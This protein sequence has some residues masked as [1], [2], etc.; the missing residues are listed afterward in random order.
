MITGSGVVVLDNDDHV[1]GIVTTDDLSKQLRGMS[2]ELAV[3]Y[4][5]LSRKNH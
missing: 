1:G 4:S 3:K 5:V 2:E